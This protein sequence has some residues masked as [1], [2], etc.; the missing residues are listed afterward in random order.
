M[1]FDSFLGHY[2]TPLPHSCQCALISRDLERQNLS[3][4]QAAAGSSAVL[5]PPL[6]YKPLLEHMRVIPQ[7]F[8]L[9]SEAGFG[10]P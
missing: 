2:L 3:S 8:P 7:C 4:E 9:L 5:Q 1:D 6:S 10:G